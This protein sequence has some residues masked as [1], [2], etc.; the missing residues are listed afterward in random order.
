MKSK[1]AIDHIWITGIVFLM[2][3][4][5]AIFPG[6]SI[7]D[8]LF[9]ISVIGYLVC[10]KRKIN[11][12]D[13]VPNKEIKLYIYIMVIAALYSSGITFISGGRWNY[14]Y[15]FIKLILYSIVYAAYICAFMKKNKYEFRHLVN[16]LLWA[17]VVQSAFVIA[18][19]LNNNLR[20]QIITSLIDNGAGGITMDRFLAYPQRSFGLGDGYWSGLSVVSG[21]LADLA[22]VFSL[23]YSSKY[24]LFIPGLL[25]TAAVNARIG[26]IVFLIGLIF[27]IFMNNNT[28]ISRKIGF[29]LIIAF[30]MAFLPYVINYLQS[31][32]PSTF[33]WITQITEHFNNMTE[34]EGSGTYY[35]LNPFY[36][37]WPSIGATIFGTGKSIFG[38]EGLANFGFS[39]DSGYLGIIYR[40]G[41]VLSFLLYSAVFFLC[42]PK[43]LRKSQ[44]KIIGI[45]CFVSLLVQN[46][47]G[48]IF[49][50]NEYYTMIIILI[51]AIYQVGDISGNQLTGR[52]ET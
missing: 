12:S 29:V 7:T 25:L 31:V 10:T 8:V 16:W 3:Y 48:G 46:Y 33:R 34:Q 49:Y 19:L 22:V 13:F 17:S 23:K 27:I 40:G 43:K 11:L 50:F 6:V 51:V 30:V 5:P 24:Y 28:S 18:M 20:T 42:I 2:I 4:R 35:H 1:R 15:T 37:R 21:I 14:G 52:K 47:K 41:L 26:L 38:T 36:W 45:L 39:S 9:V 32:A 44:Y